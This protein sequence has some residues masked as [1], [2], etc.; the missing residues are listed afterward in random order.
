MA[1][2]VRHGTADDVEAALALY[3]RSNLARRT[4][5]W[6]D[7]EERVRQKSEL[8]GA[9][10]SWFLVGFDG[11]QMVALAIAEPYHSGEKTGLFVP[12]ACFL[13]WFS[14]A[15][16][17]WGHGVGGT[18]LDNFL[19][20]ARTRGYER[21]YLFTSAENERSQRLYRRRGFEL[22]GRTAQLSREWARTL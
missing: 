10:E 11:E 20:D 14:V 15:P 13:N 7:R 6:P 17:R 18:F 22:T 21:V 9:S 5:E 2:S 3:E 8:L 4:G 19:A 16:E 12:G 1:I